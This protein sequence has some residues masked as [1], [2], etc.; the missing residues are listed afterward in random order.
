MSP[1]RTVRRTAAAT[2][3]G[4]ALFAGVALAA[5]QTDFDVSPDA[6][7]AGVTV[8]FTAHDPCAEPVTCVWDFGDGTG[9]AGG[10]GVEHVYA[11]P[12]TV[13]ATLTTDDSTDTLVATTTSKTLVVLPAPVPNRAPSAEFS[14]APTSPNTGDSVLFDSSASSDPDGDALKREWDL[15]GDGTFE[16]DSDVI[17]PFRSYAANGPVTV[18]L[19]VSDPDG[20][21]DVAAVTIEV[22]NRPPTTSIAATPA[23]PLSG[24]EVT[25]TATAADPDGTIASYA[26]D[27]DGDGVFA[28][29]VEGPSGDRAT[30]RFPLP[31]T[32][33]VGVRVRDDDGAVAEDTLAIEVG[34]RP[35]TASFTF[36]PSLVVRGE[37]VTFTASA[38][39]PEGRI[40]RVRWDFGGD[41][42]FEQEGLTATHKFPSTRTPL[43]VDLVV[44]DQD[45][46]SVVATA[47]II[48]GNLTPTATVAASKATAFSGE[49]VVF[50]ASGADREGSVSYAWDL[51]DDG[52]FVDGDQAEVTTSFAQAGLHTVR[53]LVTDDDGAS[54]TVAQEVVVQ[55]R[56]AAAT[57]A[58]SPADAPATAPAATPVPSPTPASAP[59]P[60]P[61]VIAPPRLMAP[62]PVVRFAGA[63]SRDG[64]R[65]T[66]F[67]VT[68]PRGS[69]IA[70]SCR[71]RGC[72]DLRALRSTG[73]T[74]LRALQRSY[75]AGVRIDVRVTRPGRIGKHVRITIRK[76]KPPA[77]R[78]ACLW[79]GSRKPRACS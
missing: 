68:A 38:N 61:A 66:L 40:D 50:T 42:T 5:P 77:R 53:V 44:T 56:P 31:G 49:A 58:P 15:D 12:G 43:R 46:G 47:T 25:F 24:D 60:A 20:A 35:P 41:G 79:P 55:D 23:A 13:I 26:W 28:D 16:P 37:P 8:T 1:P 2:L 9:T 48:P 36:A 4:V 52:N 30:K 62:F 10:P 75:R 11:T 74:R 14:A 27:L 73:V 39:D 45:G 71:G 34:N 32:Y 21:S 19:R 76:G 70:V 51:N 22:V 29:A 6:P 18:S 67:T 64:A 72:P 78:D 7:T 54:V 65:L 57:P 59:A 17:Q 3:I 33:E 69:R 63:L